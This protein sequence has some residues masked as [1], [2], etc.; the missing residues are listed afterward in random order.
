MEQNTVENGNAWTRSIQNAVDRAIS[1]T[2]HQRQCRCNI[3]LLDDLNN[4]DMEHETDFMTFDAQIPGTYHIVLQKDA[5]NPRIHMHNH[6]IATFFLEDINPGLSSLSIFLFLIKY[7]R[8]TH[9]ICDIVC[10]GCI[11]IRPPAR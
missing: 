1:S 11:C 7:D 2:H 9:P 8:N 3:T 5:L 6:R 4:V 10:Y